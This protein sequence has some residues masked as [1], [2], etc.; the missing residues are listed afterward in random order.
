MS[1][2][3]YKDCKEKNY[4]FIVIFIALSVQFNIA[5]PLWDSLDN[6][7]AFFKVKL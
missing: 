3:E 4:N 6:Y 5:D 2:Y 1:P 7:R